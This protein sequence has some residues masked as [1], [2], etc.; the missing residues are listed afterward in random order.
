ML[1]GHLLCG[2]V[3][4]VLISGGC[5]VLGLPWLSAAASLVVGANV[6][7]GAS[8]TTRSPW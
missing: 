4:A 8:V 1:M 7:L 6:G 2:I 3:F 5:V